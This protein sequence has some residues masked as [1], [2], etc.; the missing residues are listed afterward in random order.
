MD[1]RKR[2]IIP[3]R[4]FYKLWKSAI[5]SKT[6]GEYINN[7]SEW[8]FKKYNLEYDGFLFMLKEIFRCS[9]LTVK[10]IFD[11]AGT[12][13]AKVSNAFC[14]PIRTVEDWYSEKNKCPDYI[15]IMF[16]RYFNIMN[17]GRYIK[18]ESVAAYNEAIPRIYKKKEIVKENISKGEPMSI[19]SIEKELS[20]RSI[21]SKTDYLDDILRRRRS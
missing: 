21:L 8:N 14:I 1:N 5:S 10:E 3:D 15:K 20:S 19:D 18:V 2:K 7:N 12:S 17:L 6:I 9:R 16:L 13:K 11:C 4:E